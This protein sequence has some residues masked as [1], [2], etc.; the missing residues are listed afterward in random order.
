[1]APPS[2]LRGKYKKRGLVCQGDPG[3][4][5]DGNKRGHVDDH[6]P[7]VVSRAEEDKKEAKMRDFEADAAEASRRK[8]RFMNKKTLRDFE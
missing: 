8:K 6:H 1:M 7:R 2:F 5:P 4:H 3:L